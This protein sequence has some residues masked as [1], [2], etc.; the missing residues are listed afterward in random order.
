MSPDWLICGTKNAETRFGV[1][2]L[3]IRNLSDSVR[4]HVGVMD[5][6]INHEF[7]IAYEVKMPPPGH[8]HLVARV[9]CLAQERASN[10]RQTVSSEAGQSA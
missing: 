9:L 5:R 10:E 4:R 7:I 3:G 1:D 8:F 2:F 6:L